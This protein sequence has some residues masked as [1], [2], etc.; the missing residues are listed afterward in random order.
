MAWETR[1]NSSAKAPGVGVLL[2]AEYM[3][4]ANNSRRKNPYYVVVAGTRYYGST[5]EEAVAT[6]VQNTSTGSSGLLQ[7]SYFEEPQAQSSVFG[8]VGSALQ[9]FGRTA[10]NM[11]GRGVAAVGRGAASAGTAIAGA[12]GTVASTTRSTFTRSPS[13]DTSGSG[14]SFTQA[15]PMLSASGSSPSQS[16]SPL[17]KGQQPLT[18][19]AAVAASMGRG[20]QAPLSPS[21]PGTATSGGARRSRRKQTRRKQTRRHS[22]R[23]Q[24]RRRKQARK[25]PH[26]RR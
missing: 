7:E 5:P 22:S 1:K 15:N 14:E 25:T 23:K 20:T 18:G 6:A 4:A 10:A 24:T 17:P 12:A 3:Q 11:A 9:G 8:K 21:L 13:G 2:N 16:G 19:S 26:K